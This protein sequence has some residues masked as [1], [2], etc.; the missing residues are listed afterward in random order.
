MLKAWLQTG[1]CVWQDLRSSSASH[2]LHAELRIVHKEEVGVACSPHKAGR[3]LAASAI[4]RLQRFV[5]V[6]HQFF[7]LVQEL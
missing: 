5:S 6:S 3:V 1:C 4:H 7:L 2:L